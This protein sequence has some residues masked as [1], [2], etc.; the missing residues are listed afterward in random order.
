[1][2]TKQKAKPRTFQFLSETTIRREHFDLTK[3]QSADLRTKLAHR[4]YWVQPVVRGKI[5]W[6]VDL[7]TDYMINGD[8]DRPQ[9]QA[10]VEEYLASLPHAA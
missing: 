1:M 10:L 8:V 2:N 3:W 5:L 6:N 7:L 4:I 9:H